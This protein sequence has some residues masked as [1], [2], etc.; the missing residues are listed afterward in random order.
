ML[1]CSPIKA[2]PTSGTVSILGED[3]VSQPDN[4][5]SL[6]GVVFQNPSLDKKLTVRENLTHQGHL[7]GIYGATLKNKISS[8]LEKFDLA[9]RSKEFVEKLSGGLKRRVELA[10][11][12][13]HNP[14]ILILDEPSTGLDPRARRNL[15]DMLI[16]LSIKEGVT[17]LVTTHLAEEAEH[18]DRLTIM[19]QGELVATGA[20]DKL[21]NEIG[22]DVITISTSNPEEIA[23]EIKNRFKVNPVIVKGM[24][25]IEL[26]HGQDFIKQILE[27]YSDKVLSV[28]LGKPTLEDVF[29][30]KN[31]QVLLVNLNV[32]ERAC[33]F[34]QKVIKAR[35]FFIYLFTDYQRCPVSVLSIIFVLFM[36]ENICPL[37]RAAALFGSG[38]AGL[39]FCI[40]QFCHARMLPD[41]SIRGQALSGIYNE[42]SS[43][44]PAK[45]MQE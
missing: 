9:D 10:K 34:M 28:K 41:K 26:S 22:G 25:R 20:P 12:L 38:S 27:A 15:W 44:I 42:N 11:G 2:C 7:Y 37:N 23:K 13:L 8:Q 39:G 40:S 35:F 6:I 14:K 24:L 19:N 4:A 29:I 21:K 33:F 17:L 30:K 36:A 31:R 16:E 5:R 1:E 18:C 45:Y 3:I 32:I 43:W